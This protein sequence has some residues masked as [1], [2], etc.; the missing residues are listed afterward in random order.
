MANTEKKHKNTP[1]KIEWGK[2]LILDSISE[3]VLCCNN[4]MRV[5]WVNKVAADSLGKSPFELVGKH[6]YVLWHNRKEP[7]K[8][9]PVKKVL[10]TGKKHE[11]EMRSED[12]KY[13]FVKGYPVKDDTGNI[14]GA[15]EVTLDMTEKKHLEQK[16]KKNMEKYKI[17]VED[18][19]ELICRYDS[20]WKVS[21]V[22]DAYC[23]YFGKRKQDL[24]GKSFMPLIPAKDRH[25]VIENHKRVTKENSVVYYEHRVVTPFGEIRWQQWSNRGILDKNGK[26]TEYQAVGRDITERKVAEEAVKI[27]EDRFRQ[28]A[29]N[30]HEWIW[31]TDSEGRYTFSNQIVSEILGY[32]ADDVVGKKFV[33][34]MINSAK[35]KDLENK[36]KEI[37][38]KKISFRN[39]IKESRHRKGHNITMISSGSPIFGDGNELIGYRGVDIDVTDQ[40]MQD[41]EIKQSK[42][43]F[44][45]AQTIAKIATWEWTISSGKVTFSPNA[46]ELLE[47]DPSQN[48][49]TFKKF[50]KMIIRKN[51][52]K[53]LK[54]IR[55]FIK[56]NK[57]LQST[58][59]NE[60]TLITRKGNRKIFH[61][62]GRI[63]KNEKNIPEKM[64]GVCQ[65][66]TNFKESENILKNLNKQLLE[67][68]KQLKKMSLVDQ[69]T[70]L[71]N[72]KFLSEAIEGEFVRSKKFGYSFSVM[73]LDIDYFKS[74][75]DTY[76]HAIGD[77]VIK[78][79]SKLL[80]KL[81][82]K[83]DLIVRYGGAEFVIISSDT[84]RLTALSMASRMLNAINLYNFG[85]KK[86]FIK[87]KVS[88][89]ISAFPADIALRGIDV[90]NNADHAL[91]IAKEEGGN[92]VKC[93]FETLMKSI[94]KKRHK[95]YRTTISSLKN[96]LGKLT[97]KA[98]ESLVEAIFAL[99][100][101]IELKDHC[102]GEHVE[103]TCYYATEIAR[104]L[105][106]TY[107][108]IELVRKAAMLHDLGKVGISDKI[109]QKK[110][111]L[112]KHEFEIIKKHARIA[113]DI[114]RPIKFLRDLIPL[115]VYHHE[116]WDG[117][118][119][120]DGLKADETPIGARIIAVADVFQALMSDRPY[121]KAFNKKTAVNIITEGSGTQFDPKVVEAFLDIL[122]KEEKRD[123]KLKKIAARKKRK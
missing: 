76:G 13:W 66:I 49:F 25:K 20:S 108:D 115:I 27:S 104:N 37:F 52:R 60:Y 111:K 50:I 81:S 56:S 119:Y 41:K 61:L 17:V 109:L 9:C 5:L 120:P 23:K 117:K 116:R 16:L 88:I 21:F 26:L 92:R 74:I 45:H 11:T 95:K 62:R 53:R 46:Y 63:I 106:L 2:A 14:V 67:S 36:I 114:L 32:S 71:Y 97:K 123:R 40:I 54:S 121:R 90:V 29:N 82:R 59:D 7:C 6:C 112:T 12:G 4:D 100:R 39:L 96:K 87:L 1:K 18:Q 75:N 22:N 103:K 70:G 110:S 102:T 84:D 93:H 44:L 86:R 101:T 33:Y 64:R 113:A 51:E 118:G 48:K 69:Q 122:K 15:V 57:N 79:F 94:S 77:M 28:V 35:K 58:Y 85:T 19:T 8:G 55:K 73:L 91:N 30:A 72:H 78:Q 99:A 105:G 68:N 10:E 34:D 89:G 42:E 80:K 43:I 24:L 47:M 83:E 65:D 3:L 107:E 98:N 31:E 38:S